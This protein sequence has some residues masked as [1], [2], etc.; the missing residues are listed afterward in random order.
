[1]NVDNELMQI[2]TKEKSLE[3]MFKRV[4]PVIGFYILRKRVPAMWRS[5]RITTIKF[6]SKKVVSGESKFRAGQRTTMNTYVI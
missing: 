3:I 6:Q 2:Y 1:M 5:E 4:Q